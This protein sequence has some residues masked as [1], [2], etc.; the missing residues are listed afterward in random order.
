GEIGEGI[1]EQ[2]GG[3]SGEVSGFAFGRRLPLRPPGRKAGPGRI[4]PG[5]S[6]DA[7]RCR[8]DQ[9]AVRIRSGRPP[10]LLHT[11]V[12]REHGAEG[13]EPQAKE[14]RPGRRG[15][16]PGRLGRIAGRGV[17]R[18]ERRGRD[19]REEDEVPAVAHAVSRS[20]AF[21]DRPDSE[22]PP[23]ASGA[24]LSHWMSRNILTAPVPLN[25]KRRGG[26]GGRAAKCRPGART[27]EVCGS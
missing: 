18:R 22:Y 1:G 27:I 13:L 7:G 4:G 26:W 16:P 25:T 21:G 12:D 23:S 8:V 6:P 14:D 10:H 20:P 24:G 19:E 2:A 15:E 17:L 3:L 11:E 9:K 5:I